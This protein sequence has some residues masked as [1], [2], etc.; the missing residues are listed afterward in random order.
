MNQQL[1]LE[2]TFT[3]L[4]YSN[5]QMSHFVERLRREHKA[6]QEELHDLHIWV[7]AVGDTSGTMKQLGIYELIRA[8]AEHLRNQ[9]KAHTEWEEQQ[10]F[11]MITWYFGEGLAQISLMKREH[12]LVE[13]NI[14][15][16][17]D[18]L[19]NTP[20]YDCDKQELASY[21]VKAISILNGHCEEEEDLVAMLI[22]RSDS[23][24]Y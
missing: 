7:K 4:G 16:F 5:T 12:K 8:T 17:A 24:G 1:V 13:Q 21:L 11:P 18:A 15:R 10:L 9:L 2:N 20:D 19:D 14:Q 23:Y 6:L 3:T 22:D